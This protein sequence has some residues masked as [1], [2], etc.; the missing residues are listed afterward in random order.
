MTVVWTGIGTNLSL[1]KVKI[2]VWF[3]IGHYKQGGAVSTTISS[4]QTVT[5]ESRSQVGDDLLF[6]VC[7]AIKTNAFSPSS[8]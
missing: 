6:D 3:K 7:T 8:V 1:V 5:G 4:L 2:V